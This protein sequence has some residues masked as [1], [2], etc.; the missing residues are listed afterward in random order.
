MNFLE[1]SLAGASL[2]DP[3][4]GFSI[5]IPER[6]R[7]AFAGICQ[8]QGGAG[9]CAPEGPAPPAARAADASGMP[10]LTVDVRATSRT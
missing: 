9:A 7:G 8:A 5:P 4:N 10:Q 2:V 1:L 6:L 3:E